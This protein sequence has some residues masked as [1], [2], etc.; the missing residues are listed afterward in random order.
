MVAIIGDVEP[1]LA[2][3]EDSSSAVDLVRVSARCVVDTGMAWRGA[4]GPGLPRCGRRPCWY[5]SF[6]GHWSK[7]MAQAPCQRRGEVGEASKYAL[8]L[9]LSKAGRLHANRCA[10]RHSRALRAPP[11]R[12]PPPP[13]SPPPRC[14]GAT[15][16][17]PAAGKETPAGAHG[18]ERAL[19]ATQ[20]AKSE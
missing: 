4:R 5:H 3:I 9:K 7:V 18:R 1:S 13:P 2:A 8:E 14:I 16:V 19:S 10:H 15:V 20:A 11:M 12:P 17:G 6:A